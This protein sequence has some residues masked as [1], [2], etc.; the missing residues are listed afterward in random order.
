MKIMNLMLI[1]VPMIAFGSVLALFTMLNHLIWHPLFSYINLILTNQ[2][3]DNVAKFY[4]FNFLLIFA[5]GMSSTTDLVK[6][7][8]ALSCF[9]GLVTWV[10][11]HYWSVY[12]WYPQNKDK[13]K[14]RNDEQ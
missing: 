14:G 4:V 8:V 6:M 11:L 1:T 5:F 2:D 3:S 12:V 7:L 9:I 10:F 13:F